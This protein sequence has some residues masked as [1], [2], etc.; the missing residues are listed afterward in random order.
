MFERRHDI[1]IVDISKRPDTGAENTPLSMVPDVIDTVFMSL[2]QGLDV[3]GRDGIEQENLRLFTG[4][5]QD[6]PGEW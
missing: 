4:H 1:L 6:R 5:C 3:L 2:H